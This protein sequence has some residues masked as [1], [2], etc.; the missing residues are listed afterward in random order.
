MAD[1]DRSRALVIDP[2]VE[3]S[4]YLG[5]SGL[6]SA[7]AIAVDAAGNAYVAGFTDSSDFPAVNRLQARGGGTD[8]FVA[9]LNAAG[10]LGVLHLSGRQLGRPGLWDRR[11]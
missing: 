4:T 7:R 6:D 8:A 1:Y 9:K 11:R 3:F 10:V 2:V 5:G